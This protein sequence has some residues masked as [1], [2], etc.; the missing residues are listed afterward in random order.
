MSEIQRIEHV[1]IAVHDASE[2]VSHFERLGFALASVEDVTGGIR[3]HVMTAGEAAIEILESMDSTSTLARFLE[4]RGEG[5]HHVCLQVRDLGVAIDHAQDADC[6][7]VDHEPTV[8]SVGRR[9]FMHPGSNHGTLMGLVEH[10]AETARIIDPG[11]SDM[12]DKT[13]APGAAKRGETI[14][15]SGLNALDETGRIQHEGDMAGQARVIYAKLGE[16][17][18]AAGARP[19]D[20]VKTTDYI[21]TRNGYRATAEVR[22]EFFGE[23]RPAATGVVVSDL[24]GR[25]VLIEIDAIAVR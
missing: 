23:H 14:A 13:Y 1:A 18:R 20:V 16:V 9:V 8:D 19:G 3:S 5:L 15:V 21:V 17:L 24:I 7:L 6:A 12:A 2:A 25:G 11:W 22:R 10:H 4:H